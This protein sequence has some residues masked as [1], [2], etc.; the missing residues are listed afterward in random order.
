MNS[1]LEYEEERRKERKASEASAKESCQF[2]HVRK[3]I[4]ADPD[5]ARTSHKKKRSVLLKMGNYI[6]KGII[7]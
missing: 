5:I 4:K 2:E 7:L 1:F 6:K 3:L